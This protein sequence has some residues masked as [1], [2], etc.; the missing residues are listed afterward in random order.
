MSA[1]RAPRRRGRPAGDISPAWRDELAAAFEA[2]PELEAWFGRCEDY[3]DEA[4]WLPEVVV[5]PPPAA[6][7]GP[8]PVPGR[9]RRLRTRARC[10]VGFVADL[11]VV[12][13]TL[14]RMG[15]R[16]VRT[17]ADRRDCG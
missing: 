6:A 8:A 4:A 7:A 3:L 14:V 2:D 17:K 13:Y 15:I 5:P 12:T 16:P 9:W 1:R 10:A 11:V